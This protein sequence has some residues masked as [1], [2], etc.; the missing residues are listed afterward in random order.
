MVLSNVCD[1]I[2]EDIDDLIMEIGQNK[3]AIK[4]LL[5]AKCKMIQNIDKAMRQR[6]KRGHVFCE[7]QMLDYR[8]FCEF[9]EAETA[10]LTSYMAR[11]RQRIGQSRLRQEIL[12]PHADL[13]TL[14]KRLDVIVTL[15]ERAIAVL[16]GMVNMSGQMLGILEAK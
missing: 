15:Q 1:V 11:L 12:K 16:T 9:Y 10:I 3:A 5:A 13:V 4:S 6:A 7:A 2:A 14:H 8:E